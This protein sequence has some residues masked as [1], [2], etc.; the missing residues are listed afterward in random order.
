MDRIPVALIEFLDG[1]GQVVRSV[2]VLGWPCRLGRAVGCDVVLD[3]PHTAAVHAELALSGEALVLTVGET[4]N[5]V[6]VGG[7]HA[8]RGERLTLEPG[9]VCRL[10][11]LSLR[12]RRAEEPV[13]AELPLGLQARQQSAEPRRAPMSWRA[14]WPWAMAALL[15]SVWDLWVSFDPGTPA[16]TYLSGL[17]A[18]TGLVAAWALLWGLGSKLFSGRLQFHEHLRLALLHGMVWTAVVTVLPMISYITGWMW[19]ERVS[20]WVGAAVLCRMVWAHLMVV[21]PVLRWPFAVGV[22][23]MFLTGLGLTL[24]LNVQH[25][26][27]VWSQPYVATM[28]PP[29]WRMAP[30]ASP[31]R[32]LDDAASLK[33][34]LDQKALQEDDE[35]DLWWP[36]EGEMGELWLGA[37]LMGPSG[38]PSGDDLEMTHEE[39]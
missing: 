36:D 38:S 12:V 10:G 24:W 32:L 14:W 9:A 39:P 21:Q 31:E 5:G 20:G 25:T 7:Q 3:D 27:Q 1:H 35:S 17:L 28:L 2:S 23:A 13:P 19:P 26:G 33:P 22:S 18:S 37:A 15:W 16:R 8:L 4:V 34:A 6:W 29:A 11:H 30:L